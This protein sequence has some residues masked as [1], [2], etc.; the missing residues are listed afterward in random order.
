M[1]KNV[2]II[3]LAI[4]LSAA[5]SKTFAQS[6]TTWG[7]IWSEM[8]NL[9]YEI[10]AGVNIGGSSPMPIPG[11]IRSIESYKPGLH[12]S[13]GATITKYLGTKAKWGIAISPR[14]EIKG[15]DTKARV[16]N[17]GM[18][19]IQDGAKVSG[20]WTGMVNTKYNQSLFTF[21]VMGVYKINPRWRV[22]FGPYFSVAMANDFSGYVYEG[23]LRETDPTGD[24]ISFEGDNEASYDFSD[25]LRMIH[26]GL[27]AGV[28]WRAFKHLNVQAHLDWGL[29]DIFHSSFKTIQFGLYP[30]Y[31]NIGFGYAF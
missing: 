18:T 29:S 11:E 15:M 7:L 19:I 24:K 3:A 16:K 12:L 14:F 28:T 13:I 8:H 9:E 31:A 23:Y 4:V 1:K 30:I 10:N 20:Y 26:W 17:Y 27:E 25:N 2:I 5:S 21:P 6:S 22:M